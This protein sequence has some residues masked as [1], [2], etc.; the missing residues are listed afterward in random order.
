[1]VGANQ[2]RTQPKYLFTGQPIPFIYLPRLFKV[3]SR[4]I[5]LKTIFSAIYQTQRKC[6]NITG[7]RLQVL[8]I[9]ISIKSICSGSLANSFGTLNER[10]SFIQPTNFSRKHHLSSRFR[11]SLSSFVYSSKE[12]LLLKGFYAKTDTKILLIHCSKDRKE[13]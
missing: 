1:M 10:T 2:F 4:M 6:V 8:D 3:C 13:L 11:R 9:H 12:R 7:I 5:V